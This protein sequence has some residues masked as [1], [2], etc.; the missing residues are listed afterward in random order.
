VAND[1]AAPQYG[2]GAAGQRQQA[3]GPALASQAWQ[4]D[5]PAADDEAGP[6]GGQDPARL[7]RA[8]HM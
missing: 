7:G 4:Q 1:T 3:A 6:V 8:V 2:A 5:R